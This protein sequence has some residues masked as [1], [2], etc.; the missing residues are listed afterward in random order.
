MRNFY[1][2]YNVVKYIMKFITP[3]FHKG[4]DIST[5]FVAYYNTLN[6]IFLIV[7]LAMQSLQISKN[8]A[9]PETEIIVSIYAGK[10]PFSLA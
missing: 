8:T 4:G 9:L 6:T 10:S 5:I 1:C 3:S 7:I 2:E